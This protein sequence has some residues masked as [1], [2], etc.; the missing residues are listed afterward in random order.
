MKE[1]QAE[2]ERESMKERDS[3]GETERMR[4]DAK[5]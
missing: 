4:I 3:K 1:K 5:K 2:M